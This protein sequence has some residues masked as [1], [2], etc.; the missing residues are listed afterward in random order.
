MKI[1]DLEK[2][3]PALSIDSSGNLIIHSEI[4][5]KI[6]N[7]NKLLRIS[8]NK[9]EISISYSFSDIRTIGSVRLGIITLL[10]SFNEDLKIMF[11]NGG[12]KLE[13]HKFEGQFNQAE[14]ASSFVSSSR[15]LGATTGEIIL[16]NKKNKIFLKWDNSKSAVLPMLQNIGIDKKL[17]RI[18][19]SIQE[20]DDTLKEPIK[21][22]SF[23][24]NISSKK[25]G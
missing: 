18:L 23:K 9:E 24:I 11:V 22:S 17:S 8:R 12:N 21:L 7:I 6:G 20:F 16:I 19:F 4:K 13:S 25:F 1:T 10:E 15:G 2:V 14:Q 5:T 3:V